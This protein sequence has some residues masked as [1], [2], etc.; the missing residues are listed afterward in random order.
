MEVL[1]LNGKQYVKASKA[2]KDL[3]Y[4][5]DYVGQLCRSGT[6]DAHL[7][8]R[9]WYVNPDTLGA[10][11]IEKRRNARTKAREYAKKAIQESRDM[12]VK[13]STN[14]YRNIAIRYQGDGSD[15]VPPVKKVHIASEEFITEKSEDD[16]QSES[17][18]VLN[19]NKKI[20]MS[21]TIPV[22]D[23]EEETP[24]TDTTVLLPH[25]LRR[26]VTETTEREGAKSNLAVLEQAEEQVTV[27][28]FAEKLN[29]LGAEVPTPIPVDVDDTVKEDTS[30]TPRSSLLARILPLSIPL[31]LIIIIIALSTLFIE[32][33]AIYTE[34]GFQ[35]SYNFDSSDVLK[36]IKK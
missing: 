13:T 16:T 7:V 36:Y 4:A 32:Y 5:S 35:S 8:G 20:I 17:Y 30:F 2:A 26:H 6:V 34:S 25:I 14:T 15:L 18:E 31:S 3:G 1:T 12:S 19:K 24:L 27:V 9:T 28:P 21:G 22:Y 29:K 10:H 33:T 11:R 23:A